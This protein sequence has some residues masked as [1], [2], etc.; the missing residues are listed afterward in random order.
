MANN[1]LFIRCTGCG[2]RIMI[3]KGYL[4]AMGY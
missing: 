4:G 3:A 2:K 1:R